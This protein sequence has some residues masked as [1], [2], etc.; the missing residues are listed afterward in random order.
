MKKEI[1]IGRHGQDTDNASGTLN[2]R[3]NNH[4]THLGLNQAT[5]LATSIL[6]SN[7][8]ITK[9]LSSP[10][11]RAFMTASYVADTLKLA[12]PEKHNLLLERDFGVMTGKQASEI[13]KLCAPDI[14][15]TN[16]ITYFLSPEG[17]ETF[18]QLL[19]RG[20]KVLEWLEK[21]YSNETV[22]LLTHGDIGK[23]IYASFYGLD[24][25]DVLT[26]FHFG[27]SEVLMLKEGSSPEERHV[28]SAVQHNH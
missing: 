14:I 2:G 11:E 27:N 17:A 15:K 4:L 9:I 6:R 20:K 16:T 7:L 24:W 10:L 13:E 12:I 5:I 19:D 18:P 8:G 1:Y 28:H 21:D 3:R 23:M 25:R 22:L 26:G